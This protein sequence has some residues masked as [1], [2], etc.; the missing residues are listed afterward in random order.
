MKKL[1]TFIAFPPL[2]LI[3]NRQYSTPQL[4]SQ[5]LKCKNYRFL[6]QNLGEKMQCVI[7]YLFHLFRKQTCI[8]HFFNG[9][10]YYTFN[11]HYFL[12]N[13]VN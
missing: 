2:Y 12:T 13:I 7:K 10:I 3:Q 1:W 6:T 8:N 5:I 4:Q 11:L 9:T